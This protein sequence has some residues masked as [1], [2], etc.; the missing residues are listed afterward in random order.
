VVL[1]QTLAEQAAR[2][3]WGHSYT[4]KLPGR[5][6]ADCHERVVFRVDARAGRRYIETVV[7]GSYRALSA[8][9]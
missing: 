3:G 2:A 8:W 4:H 7:M 1:P 6:P 9:M 5:D